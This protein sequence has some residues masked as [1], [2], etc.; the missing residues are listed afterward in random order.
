MNLNLCKTVI[1]SLLIDQIISH[2]PIEIT[3]I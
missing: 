1:R 2:I 3:D